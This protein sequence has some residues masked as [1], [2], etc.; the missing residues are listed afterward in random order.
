[1]TTDLE[2]EDLA[3]LDLGKL[4]DPSA[5]AWFKRKRPALVKPRVETVNDPLMGRV[6]DI[7]VAPPPP[8][9]KKKR[10]WRYELKRMQRWDIGTGYDDIVQWLVKAYSRTPARGGLAGT[11]LAIDYT[12]VGVAVVEWLRKELSAAGAKA[13]IRPIWIHGGAKAS[14]NPTSG[15]WNVPKRELVSALQVLMGTKRLLVEQSMANCGNLVKEFENFK[16]KQ[17]EATGHESFE[18]WREHDHDDMVLAAA[19]ALW[20]GEQGQREFWVR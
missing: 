10:R 4:A 2:I 3:G 9:D 12:G 20:T 15:G 5:F 6:T 19:I 13:V 14:P 7:T 17:N 18:A 11:V 8:E 16:V 1:M